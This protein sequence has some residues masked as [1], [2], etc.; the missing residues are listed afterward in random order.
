MFGLFLLAVFFIVFGFGWL[1]SI[2]MLLPPNAGPIHTGHWPV[3][4]DLELLGFDLP[5]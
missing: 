5:G 2:A 4:A 3:A 1:A